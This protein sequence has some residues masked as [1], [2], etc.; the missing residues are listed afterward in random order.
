MNLK[1]NWIKWFTG[2][3]DAEGNFQLYPKKR[4]LKSGVVSKYNVGLGFHLSLHSRDTELLQNIHNNINNIG[5]F[6]TYR[7]R[8][9]VRIAVNDRPGLKELVGLFESFPLVT[10]H[11]Y[12]RY[13]LLKKFLA[14]D[15]K[16][17][18]T[19]EEFN[20]FK[21]KCL[22]DINLAPKVFSDLDN[23][24]VSGLYDSWIVGFINGEGSFYMNKGRCNFF[25]E[26]TD[27]QSLDIIKKRLDF[28][29]SIVARSARERDVGKN[30]KPTYV[31]I[32]S[33]KKDLGNLIEFLDS[34]HVVQLAGHKLIQYRE[35]K[36]KFF[37]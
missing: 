23:Q 35:W 14:N 18:K 31:L 34:E 22:E 9:E 25:I 4:V 26:H 27:L 21:D 33:S 19:L 7:N 5:T 6:Y 17:F 11:Q 37:A 1:N 36:T 16:E 13:C 10:V 3:C 28:N 29:P 2:F 24:I 30:I 20:T 15:V 8:E 32:V 12:T